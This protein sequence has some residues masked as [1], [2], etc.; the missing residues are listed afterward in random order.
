MNAS[1]Q[2]P[3]QPTAGRSDA[4]HYIMKASPFQSTLASASG[5]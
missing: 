4:P 5:S 3:L 2:S 1:N